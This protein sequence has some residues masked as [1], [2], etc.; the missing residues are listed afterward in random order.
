MILWGLAVIG[1]LL[2]AQESRHHDPLGE[3]WWTY[4]YRND[5]AGAEKA[6]AAA[7]DTL[8][9]DVQLAFVVTPR[10]GPHRRCGRTWPRHAGLP[11][12]YH[13]CVLALGHPGC[14]GDGDATDYDRLSQE[15][16][17]TLR[18]YLDTVADRVS[19]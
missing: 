10:P 5:R 2:A 8:Q 7:T 16:H 6:F 17:S 18:R 13:I 11:V 3:A 12:S 4:V 1:R 14:C 15:P 19:A 9:K